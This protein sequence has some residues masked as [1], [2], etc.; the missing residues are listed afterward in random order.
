MAVT[1]QEL[2]HG[3][4]HG[5]PL[6]EEELLALP[7]DGRK[8]ELVDGRAMEVPTRWEHGSLAVRFIKQLLSAGADDLGTLA[9]SSTGF[10]MTSG[11]V[12]SPDVAFVVRDRVPTGAAAKRFFDGAPDLAIEI[13]SPSEDLE[14]AARKVG[15][16]LTSGCQQVWQV[17]PESRRIVVYRSLDLVRTHEPEEEITGGELLPSLR[18]QVGDLLPEE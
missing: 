7:D 10:R 12:R 9:D 5:R 11:N 8:Y 14:D 2:E 16:Y 6:T 15:E 1:E 4:F 13:I 18:F 17:F 3:A